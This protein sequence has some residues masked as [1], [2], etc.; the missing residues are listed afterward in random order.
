[1]AYRISVVVF[2]LTLTACG[3]GQK[4][5]RGPAF[6]E[7]YETNYIANCRQVCEADLEMGDAAGTKACEQSCKE[8]LA[9]DDT[10]SADCAK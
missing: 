7:S 10:W 4:G 2:A 6:C 8:D 3:G 1:M 5:P 9:D